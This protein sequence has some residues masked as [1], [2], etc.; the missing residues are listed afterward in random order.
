MVGKMFSRRQCQRVQGKRKKTKKKQGWA[1]DFALGVILRGSKIAVLGAFY[2][3]LKGNK[4]AGVFESRQS[5]L[6]FAVE[7]GNVEEMLSRV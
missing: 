1:L 5:R 4:F 7:R 2:D 6:Q 3:T